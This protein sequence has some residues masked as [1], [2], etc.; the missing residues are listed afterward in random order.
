VAAEAEPPFLAQEAAAGGTPST[1]RE[2]TTAEA[3]LRPVGMRNIGEVE[4]PETQEDL[5]RVSRS[6]ASGLGPDNPGDDRNAPAY[7]RKYMD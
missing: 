6:E 2:P 1:V 5:P 3:F 4:V 7:I